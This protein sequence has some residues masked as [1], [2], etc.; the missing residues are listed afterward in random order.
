M[1]KQLT[2]FLQDCG[3]GA[4]LDFVLESYSK[5]EIRQYLTLNQV[6]IL[7]FEEDNRFDVILAGY[8]AHPA[9]ILPL[10]EAFRILE[11]Y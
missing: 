3:D 11:N 1:K 8:P 2:E 4:S 6:Q 7:N 10:V 9:F 5:E